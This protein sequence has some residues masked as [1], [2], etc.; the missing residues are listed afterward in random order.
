MMVTSNHP[1]NHEDFQALVEILIELKM[2][3]LLESQMI[4]SQKEVFL[5]NKAHFSIHWPFD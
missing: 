3:P 2:Y 5:L 4:K 1:T